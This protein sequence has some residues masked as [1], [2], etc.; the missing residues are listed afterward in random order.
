MIQNIS[1]SDQQKIKK[2]SNDIEKYR[3]KLKNIDY[4][5]NQEV[6]FATMHQFWRFLGTVRNERLCQLFL[7]SKYCAKHGPFFSSLEHYYTRAV[8]VAEA[9][10]IITKQLSKKLS[11]LELFDNDISKESYLQTNREMQMLDFKKCKKM[12][13][14]GCGCLPETM[15]YIYENTPIK[16]IIGV[17]NHQEAIYIA[18]EMIRNQGLTDI[19]LLHENSVNYDYKDAD[20]VLISNM[21]AGKKKILDRIVNTSQDNIQILVR[22]PILLG[23]MFYDNAIEDLNKRLAIIKSKKVSDYFLENTVLLRKLAI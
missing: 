23:H 14:V 3:V 20:I 10:S 18:G 2:L 5:N 9:F 17:D 19:H 1:K 7:H 13:I 6:F 15:L 12:V 11:F 16:E 8:E 4:I 21:M 22:T